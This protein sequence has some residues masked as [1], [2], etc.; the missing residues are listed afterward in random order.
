MDEK[1]IRGTSV[2]SEATQLGVWSG[3]SKK[4]KNIFKKFID[5]VYPKALNFFKYRIY[6]DTCGQTVCASIAYNLFFLS[7]KLYRK[8]PF[9]FQE[10][11]FITLIFI[12]HKKPTNKTHK[13]NTQK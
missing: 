7:T 10:Q 9:N 8:I 13:Y 2:S 5:L 6:I 11:A 4:T 12:F 1:N 3:A